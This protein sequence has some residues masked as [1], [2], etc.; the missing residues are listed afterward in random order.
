MKQW[1]KA[2]GLSLVILSS[3]MYANAAEAA[4]KI[5]YVATG[6]AMAQLAKRYNVQDKLRKEFSGRVN[7]LRSLEKK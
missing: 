4:Q 6:Q 7:E 2:A 3:S 5:G 1:V